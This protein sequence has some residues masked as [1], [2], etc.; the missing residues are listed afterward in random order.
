MA[1]KKTFNWLK[2]GCGVLLFPVCWS[3]FVV[4][5]RVLAATGPV[6]VVW[7]PLV[8]GLL[9]WGVVWWLLPEPLWVYVLGH[10][11]THALWAWMFGGRLKK[12]KVTSR[13]GYVVLSKS[14]FLITL[15]PYFFPFYA[16]LA[17][18]LYGAGDSL[19]GWQSYRAVFLVALG[20][21]YGF[22]VTMTGSILRTRQPDLVGEGW[23]FSWVVIVLGNLL[24]LNLSIPLL[25][26]GV[27]VLK[28]LI[29]WGSE[30]W[31][32]WRWLLRL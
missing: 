31:H 10:E 28:P 29:W 14:N 20:A 27:P 3:G 11:L 22:H 25:T 32:L 2:M 9:C 17:A 6:D 7:V 19:W 30:S 23:L 4:L 26:R 13:G 12:I 18:A 21:A 5:A 8:S 15:A 16:V 1:R 24:V